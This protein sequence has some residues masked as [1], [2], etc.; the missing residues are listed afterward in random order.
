MFQVFLLTEQIDKAVQ[1]FDKS[2]ELNPTFPT[3]YVQKL[4]TDYRQAMLE[5]S[6]VKVQN[7]I[8][9]FEQ[10]IEKYPDCIETYA[11]FSQ[12]G[13]ICRQHKIKKINFQI[14]N[15]VILILYLYM[16]LNIPCTC[17]SSISLLF[18][19]SDSKIELQ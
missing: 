3:A 6:Q 5:N 7:I 19:S 14:T 16:F 17:L 1:D 8:N 2:V 13:L 12:V 9:L 18:L 11:L 10:A 15:S 4:Y